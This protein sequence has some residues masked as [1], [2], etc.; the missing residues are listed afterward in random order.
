MGMWPHKEGLDPNDVIRERVGVATIEEKLVQ[1]RLRWFGHI[2]RRP[3][4]ASVHIGRLRRADKCQERS[5]E[6]KLDLGGVYEERPEGLGYQQRS[7]SGQGCVEVSYPRARTVIWLRYLLGF[8]SS[9]P[10]LV[11]D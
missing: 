10:Q 8:S 7:S 2:Q 11:W 3:S 9:L 5:G 1:H 6:A 4:E